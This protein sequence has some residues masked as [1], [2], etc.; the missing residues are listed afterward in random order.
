MAPKNNAEQAQEQYQSRLDK[1]MGTQGVSGSRDDDVPMTGPGT[2]PVWSDKIELTP[3][4]V[5]ISY[6]KLAQGL[7]PE[8]TQENSVTRMGQWV[9]Q[10]YPPED[11]VVIV[12]LQYAPS[13]RFSE[14]VEGEFVT[15]CYSPAGHEHGIGDPGIACAVCPLKEWQPTDQV[16]ERGRKKNSPPPCQ[17]AQEFLAWSHTHQSLVRLSFKS[18]GSQAGRQLAMLGAT[19][20]LGQFP[21]KLASVRKSGKYTYAVPTIEL[22]PQEQW[23]ELL[24]VAH[25]MKALTSG[26]SEH[27]FDP[28]KE[29]V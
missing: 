12:P 22:I 6:L 25:S 14:Q 2:L 18:T 28:T 9:L 26:T 21:V 3:D 19:R 1:T 5:S 11:N 29:A 16:D 24:S 17:L 27:E 13:R 8:V 4:Q 7:S 20:G 10:G 23:G 15:H